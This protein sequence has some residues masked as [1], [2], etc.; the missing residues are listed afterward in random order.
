MPILTA[1]GHGMLLLYEKSTIKT[2]QIISISWKQESQTTWGLKTD[3]VN[4]IF[5]LTKFLVR[6]QFFCKWPSKF[7]KQYD[8]YSITHLRLNEMT[9]ISR[10]SWPCNANN[11]SKKQNCL[12]LLSYTARVNC[13]IHTHLSPSSTPSTHHLEYAWSEVW[14]VHII[15]QLTTAHNTCTARRIRI[16]SLADT[17]LSDELKRSNIQTASIRWL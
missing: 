4:V 12:A 15:T 13:S 16:I 7:L 11:E 17:Q 10:L 2:L 5:G 14:T 8:W 1:P 9:Q 6:H 3:D